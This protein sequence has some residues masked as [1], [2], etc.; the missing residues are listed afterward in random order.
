M[1]LLFLLLFLILLVDCDA[2]FNISTIGSR[3]KWGRSH[4]HEKMVKA[5]LDWNNTEEDALDVK[6]SPLMSKAMF[7]SKFG[8][9]WKLILPYFHP[10]PKRRK[11]LGNGMRQMTKILVTKDIEFIAEVCARS[12]R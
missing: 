9:P 2:D 7:A 5:I 3:I 6:G 8:N 10:D 4:H 12:D 1:F 11:I